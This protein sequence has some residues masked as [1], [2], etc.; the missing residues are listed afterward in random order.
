MVSDE[1]PARIERSAR[2]P[3]GRGILLRCRPGRLLA[4][5]LVVGPLA[6]LYS[7]TMAPA[8]VPAC[9]G[10][11]A[12]RLKRDRQAVVVQTAD[13]PVVGCAPGR[14]RRTHVPLYDPSDFTTDIQELRLTGVYAAWWES[15]DP[16]Q[17]CKYQDLQCPPGQPPPISRSLFRVNL[18]NG[19]RTAIDVGGNAA[20]AA[21]AVSSTGIVAWIELDST[22]MPGMLF[23]YS[24]AGKQMLDS[25]GRIDPASLKLSGNTIR[26]SKNGQPQV[27]TL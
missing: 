6:L 24:R 18:R 2:A 16:T 1:S 15:D 7:P 22:Q 4:V 12:T 11:H 23:A 13:G 9:G 21:L 3:L 26:W 5:G 17:G 25:G 10:K 27:R 8:A 20:P 19:R 14:R